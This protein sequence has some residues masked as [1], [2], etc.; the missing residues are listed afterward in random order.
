MPSMPPRDNDQI[1]RR[2][3]GVREGRRDFRFYPNILYPLG[4]RPLP[5]PFT[6]DAYLEDSVEYHT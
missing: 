5:V 1:I 4:K 6:V 2:I 3:A